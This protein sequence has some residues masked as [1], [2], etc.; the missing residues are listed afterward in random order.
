MEFLIGIFVGGFLYWLLVD[1]K[2]PSGTLIIDLS[3]PMNDNI[4][5]LEVHEDLNRIYN[6]KTV[7]LNVKTY[8]LN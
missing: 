1:R 8:S 4:F 3:D 5:S 6:K 7:L 2:K